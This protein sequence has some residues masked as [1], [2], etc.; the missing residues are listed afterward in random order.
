MPGCPG[1]GKNAGM[2]RVLRRAR[3]GVYQ[4]GTSDYATPIFLAAPT[5]TEI[6]TAGVR[7]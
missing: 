6:A 7:Q 1:A 2:N 3:C 5:R 4:S